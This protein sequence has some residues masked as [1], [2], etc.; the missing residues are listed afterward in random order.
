MCPDTSWLGLTAAR[1]ELAVRLCSEENSRIMHGKTIWAR[2]PEQL[3]LAENE[4]HVWRAQ[5]D[6]P[7]LILSRFLSYLTAAEV[8]RAE[9]FVFRVDRN[10]FIAG[11]GLLRELLARYSGLAPAAVP[12]RT[13]SH[14]KPFLEPQMAFSD[15]FF[16]ISHSQGAALLAFS[17]SGQL[18]ID[19]EKIRPDFGTEEIAQRYFSPA[20]IQELSALPPELQAEGFFH[21]WTRKE[22]CVKASGEGL[23]I[24][25]DSFSVS[26]TPGQP[27]ILKGADLSGWSLY[28]IDPGAGFVG[29]CVAEGQTGK[30]RFF[31]YGEW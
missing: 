2:P 8:G 31:E 21:C 25:L 19:I 26:L 5:L 24:P 6:V 15:V 20:E 1:Y 27:A 23:R 14:G 9:R 3:R 10:R 28:S 13:Y 12:I 7:D 29:A 11:R 16:N 17:S 4:I 22:A 18:G 30:F